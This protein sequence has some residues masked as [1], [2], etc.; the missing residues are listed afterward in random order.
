MVKYTILRSGRQR[1]SDEAPFLHDE[2]DVQP[3]ELKLCK[4]LF[5]P[6]FI[7]RVISLC[8]ARRYYG[9]LL[10]ISD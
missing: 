3:D 9:I 8:P 7:S 6:I 5:G 4:P 2:T 1:F 10:D